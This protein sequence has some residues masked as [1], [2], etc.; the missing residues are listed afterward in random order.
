MELVKSDLNV[1]INVAQGGEPERAYLMFI[2]LVQQ[3]PSNFQAWLWLSELA[4]SLEEQ[5]YALE[6]AQALCPPDANGC[7]DLQPYLNE[8]RGAIPLAC[9][10]TAVP[11]TMAFVA[12]APAPSE[13]EPAATPLAQEEPLD[14]EPFYCTARLSMIAESQ[15]PKPEPVTYASINLRWIMASMALLL[16]LY[17]FIHSDWRQ[18]PVPLLSLPS[19]LSLL[20]G[21]LLVAASG[22]TYPRPQPLGLPGALVMVTP[23]QLRLSLR[24]AG[25]LLV[26]LPFTILLRA[27]LL[28]ALH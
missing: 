14:N 2:S 28:A 24:W 7:R 5:T 11:V 17:I 8:L 3:S 22:H 25:W 15:E 19:L 21:C 16:I 10:T 18:F 6:R 1:A 12:A 23:L 9:P 4:K 27:A 20:A 13:P 26:F